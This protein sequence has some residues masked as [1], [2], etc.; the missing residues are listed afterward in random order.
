MI[1]SFSADRTFRHCQ[2]WWFYKNSFGNGNA[3]KVRQRREAYVLSK[4]QT[5]GAIR[6]DVVDD[7]LSVRLIP[8]LNRGF[9]PD[10]DQ[11]VKM[12]LSMFDRRMTVVREHRLEEYV[13]NGTKLPDD[14]TI[15][16]DVEYGDG[17]DEDKVEEARAEVEKAVKNLYELSDVL[18]ELRGSSYVISQRALTYRVADFSVKAVPDVIA[19]YDDAPPVVLDWKVHFFGNADAA[20][21]LASYSLALCKVDPH[22]DFPFA[23]EG[24]PAEETRLLEAQLLTPELREHEFSANEHA[25]LEEHIAV[26]AE[27]MNLAVAGRKKAS[28]FAPEDFSP[29]YEPRQCQR[30]PFKRLC[31]E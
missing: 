17:I 30:C 9:I 29:A 24:F 1:W 10:C 25:S 18:D 7:V 27:E 4:L 22:R 14:F 23:A 12:A 8:A 21:Q 6:G 20:K 11:L 16:F 19:F 31:W 28:D 5:I 15:L 26:R 2:R 13:A 3:K